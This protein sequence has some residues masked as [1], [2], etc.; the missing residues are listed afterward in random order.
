MRSRS[1]DHRPVT[2]TRALPQAYDAGVTACVR[3][4]RRSAR[5]DVVRMVA[6][7][8]P[9]EPAEGSWSW[10]FKPADGDA[11]DALDARGPRLD[12]MLSDRTRGVYEATWSPD[13]GGHLSSRFVVGDLDAA[14]RDDV[15]MPS[16]GVR[17]RLTRAMWLVAVWLVL[18][19]VAGL[20]ATLWLAA[21]LWGGSPT[22]VDDAN[23]DLPRLLVLAALAGATGS[24]GAALRSF[25]DR[26][27][28]GVEFDNCNGERK[29][30]PEMKAGTQRFNLNIVPGLV[31]RPLLGAVI[32][33]IAYAVVIVGSQFVVGADGVSSNSQQVLVVLFVAGLFGMFAKSVWDNLNKRARHLF[34][35][36]GE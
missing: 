10:R 34:A 23:D 25:I 15:E 18:V 17:S 35:P 3:I 30:W 26:T 6:E 29:Q 20:V 32:A 21:D 16:R 33:P 5:G 11:W 24:T 7:R 19:G 14:A 36:P 9:D 31:L 28:N 8:L 2:S 12:V 4:R 22:S 1:A 27:G 13:E